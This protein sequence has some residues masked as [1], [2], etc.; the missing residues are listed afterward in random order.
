MDL[1]ELRIKYKGQILELAE[2]Y[3]ASNVRIFGSLARGQATSKSDIDILVHFNK[4][5]SLLDES[6]LGLELSDLI[7]QKVD[8]IGD[9]AI[10][11][12]LKP[13]IINEARPL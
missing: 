4:K 5:A 6:A 1:N 7:G 12:E 13:F 2:K 11:I 3:N 8:I 9:D 10:R